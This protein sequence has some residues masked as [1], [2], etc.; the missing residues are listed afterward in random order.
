MTAMRK[1]SPSSLLM[2]LIQLSFYG[3]LVLLILSGCLLA[4]AP[5]VDP[6]RVEVGLAVPAA[7]RIESQTH[8]ITKAPPG[9]ENIHLEDARGSLRFSPH[10]KI[11]VAGTALVLMS[12][13]LLL[14]WVLLQ[15]RAVFRT[16]HAGRPFV[17]GNATRIRRIGCAVIF[18]EVARALLVY[19]GMHY[20]AAHF[21]IR[22][23]QL[24]VRPDIHGLTVLYGLLIV[25]IAEV[26][27]EGTRLDE[28]Q[29]LT[30]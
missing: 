21:S 27:R 14:L 8:E 28:D 2:I 25:A 15:L 16:I 22:G 24:E 3:T 17:Y 18:G 1:G 30:I 23:L 7:F 5:W 4:I 10:G 20:A 13:L 9:M 29:S 26:F 12:G 19:I 6:P 11:F